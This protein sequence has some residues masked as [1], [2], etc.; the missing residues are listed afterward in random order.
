[1]KISPQ[2]KRLFDKL[3]SG[4]TVI[5]ENDPDNKSGHFFSLVDGGKVSHRMVTSLIHEG[6]LIPVGDGL[7][8]DTQSYALR[9][10]V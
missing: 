6:W 4:L 3:S 9:K 1:M 8:G 5:R 7:F 2:R 10:N